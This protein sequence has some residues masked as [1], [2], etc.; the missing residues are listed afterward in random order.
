MKTSILTFILLLAL[1]ARG[2]TATTSRNLAF[3]YPI[4]EWE[5][6]LVF[7][8]HSSQDVTIPVTNWT[9]VADTF[10]MSSNVLPGHYTFTTSNRVPIYATRTFF[11]A[12]ASN[13]VGM[14]FSTVLTLR[15]PG[16][17]VNLRV[18]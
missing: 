5:T 6:N 17:G 16:Q 10:L 18:Q 4:S 15:A 1:A 7:R 12:S 13:Q 9:V 11:A 14:V 2:Q 8:I 3:D